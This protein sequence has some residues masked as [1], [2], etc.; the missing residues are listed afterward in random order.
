[1]P[2]ELLDVHV[3]H[4]SYVKK[5]AN[6]K[7]FFF[8]KSEDEEMPN[9]IEVKVKIV[10]SEG[11]E[12]KVYGIVYSPDEI[13]AQGHMMN[14]DTIEK[15]CHEF[16]ENYRK[17]DKQHDYIEGAGVVLE[18]YI[19]LKDLDFN[20]EAISEGSWVLVTRA[21]E[22]NYASIEKGE[23]TG[24]SLA[25]YAERVVE[26]QVEDT[27]SD[28]VIENEELLIGEEKVE[29]TIEDEAESNEV[30]EVIEEI[31]VVENQETESK[32]ETVVD[33]SID[34]AMVALI[35]GMFD[36]ITSIDESIKVRDTMIAEYQMRVDS[37]EKSINE[38]T[39]ERKTQ[40]VNMSAKKQKLIK[41]NL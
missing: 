1:M 11:A 16:N 15:A 9:P 29:V 40:A 12:R 2:K 28:V 13:D 17:I 39:L 18:S 20:G 23:I 38:M 24:Y 31:I 26:K 10:K 6:K 41:V 5:P 22:E 7:R 19:L 27:E 21:T 3:T 35:K 33:N 37:L 8:F 36:K 34:N 25:G 32:P 30:G 14:R 4:V